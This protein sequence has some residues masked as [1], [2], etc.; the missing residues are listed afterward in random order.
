M[1]KTLIN[2]YNVPGPRYTS[3]PTVPYWDEAGS[4][5]LHLDCGGS[6][7]YPEGFADGTRWTDALDSDN[8][9]SN[10]RGVFVDRADGVIDLDRVHGGK[11]R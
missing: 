5:G 3:Y 10:N 11:R 6:D 7:S 4:I 2:K 1:N 9:R 8:A